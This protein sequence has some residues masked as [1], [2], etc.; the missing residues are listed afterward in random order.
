MALSKD[1]SELWRR[2]L[3]ASPDGRRETVDILRQ[4]YVE[5][6]QAA[7]RFKQHAQEMQYPQFREK[8]LPYRSGKTR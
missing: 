1:W 5:E 3:G 2:F 4:R 8:L 7:D 6:V